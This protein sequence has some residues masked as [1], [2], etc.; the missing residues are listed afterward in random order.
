LIKGEYAVLEA[1]VV[2]ATDQRIAK[3]IRL[4]GEIDQILLTCSDPSEQRQKLN[5]L[6]KHV[7]NANLSTVC[8]KRE[9]E[10]PMVG[11]SFDLL[12][13]AA[14]VVSD[15]WHDRTQP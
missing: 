7:D 10:I 13:A 3:A 15:W 1:D 6:K 2:E 12:Q 8:D 9:L 5:D 4:I 11:R 14:M